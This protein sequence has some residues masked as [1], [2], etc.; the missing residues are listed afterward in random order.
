MSNDVLNRIEKVLEQRKVADPSS[1]YVSGLYH[2]GLNKILE[3]IGEEATET[4]IAAKDMSIDKDAYRDTI[5]SGRREVIKENAE[6][7]QML[8]RVKIMTIRHRHLEQSN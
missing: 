1:S 2:S 4:I 8:Q 7:T 3:K 5:K 6:L